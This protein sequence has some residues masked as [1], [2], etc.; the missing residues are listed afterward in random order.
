MS[1]S[2]ADSASEVAAAM[3]GAALGAA[4]MGG[5]APE[6]AALRE[7]GCES[8]GNPQGARWGVMLA[9][10]SPFLRG[11]CL[12]GLRSLLA[13]LQI[14]F[15]DPQTT[16]G[17]KITI[18]IRGEMNREAAPSLVGGFLNKLAERTVR[19]NFC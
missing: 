15:G 10:A 14:G 3:G 13:I 6:E 8:W 19:L 9:C 17:R 2:L 16:M 18:V 1:S 5:A 7:T 11:D 4:L 12:V